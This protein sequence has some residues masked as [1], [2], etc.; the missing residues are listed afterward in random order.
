MGK[1]EICSSAESCKKQEASSLRHEKQ[2]G[3]CVKK[4]KIKKQILLCTQQA[5]GA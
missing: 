3:R 4:R 2:W 5:Q 1:K